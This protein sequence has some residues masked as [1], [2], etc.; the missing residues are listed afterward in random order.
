[1]RGCSVIDA[2]LLNLHLSGFE[3]VSDQAEPLRVVLEL[4]DALVAPLMRQATYAG[5]ARPITRAAAPVMV[6]VDRQGRFEIEWI[7]A[8][9]AAVVLLCQHLGP[10]FK[11]QTVLPLERVLTSLLGVVLASL[12]PRPLGI[13]C[14]LLPHVLAAVGESPL[15]GFCTFFIG[16]LIVWNPMFVARTAFR[17]L[18]VLMPL[19]CTA[20]RTLAVLPA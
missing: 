10:T 12:C 13:E 6:H 17:A 3:V 8:Q 20:W 15:A 9:I 1:M 4:P 18:C 14:S 16:V 7:K 19:T 2:P 11:R 5:P